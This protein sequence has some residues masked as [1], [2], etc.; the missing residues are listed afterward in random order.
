MSKKLARNII[1]FVIL[2]TVG[3]GYEMSKLE[4]DYEFE[5]FFPTGDPDLEFYREFKGKFST[6]VDFVLMALRNDKGAF[7]EDFLKDAYDLRRQLADVRHVKRIFSPFDARDYA[8]GPFGP[9]AIPYLHPDQPERLKADSI[10]IYSHQK[11]IGSLFSEDGRSI[12]LLIEVDEGLSK[13]KTDSVYWDIMDVVSH[14]HFDQLHMAGKVV[15][16]AYYINQIKYEFVFFFTLGVLLIVVVLAIIYRSL[17]ATVIP[18]VVVLLSVLWLLGFMGMTGK[19]IDIMT[20]LLPLVLFVVGI[21]DVIHLLSRYFE[22]LRKGNAKT[23]AIRIAYK[24]VGIATF[25]TSLTTAIGFLTLLTSG[26]RPVRELGVYAAVG[27]LVAFILAFILLPAILSLASVPRI[28]LREPSSIFW[29]KLVRRIFLVSMR[30]DRIIFAITILLTI[31]SLWGITRIRI[32]NFLLEDVGK[33]DP[34]RTSFEYFEKHFAGVRPFELQVSVRDSTGSLFQ[35]ESIAEMK[36]IERYLKDEYGVGFLVSPLNILRTAN[37]ALNGGRDSA[38]SVPEDTAAL[39]EAIRLAEKFEKRPEFTALLVPG[40]REGRF[41]G[42]VVDEGGYTTKLKNDALLR[43]FRERVPLQHLDM[44]L[45]GMS[46]LIDKNN[47]TLSMNMMW[48]LLIALLVVGSIMGVLFRSLRLMVISLIPNILPL[49]VLGGIM[50]WFGINLKVSTSI[51]FGIAFGI[52]VDDTIHFLVKYLQEKKKGKPRIIALRRTSVSTGKAIILTTV[53]LCA[54]F[55]SL[56]V[57]DFTSTFYVGSL[58]SLTLA[59]ALLADLFLLPA[60]LKRFYR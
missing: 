59:N 2:L 43:Y 50:G 14:Y 1:L 46:L 19:S 11:A 53:I 48:G 37:Q 51:V 15:G 54:G 23:D 55:I 56:A 4:F 3:A 34:H 32:D 26:I 27:V 5:H 41:S 28:A 16:Q 18:L 24:Q 17:W 10:R 40:Y 47:E 29:N 45:T 30:R 44:R 49:L 6:D 58:I 31:A 35:P 33:D 57:S 20:T 13:V 52:A 9:I 25:L 7:Q 38:Y 22:E 8:L 36:E 39:N 21:S 12:S 60:L 42:K